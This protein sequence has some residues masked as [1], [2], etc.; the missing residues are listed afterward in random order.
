MRARRFPRNGDFLFCKLIDS[1]L[2]E[3]D[4]SGLAVP[5]YTMATTPMQAMITENNLRRSHS[6]PYSLTVKTYAQK[7]LEFQSAV[8]SLPI[9]L[10]QG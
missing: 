3:S 9:L 4:L 8:T 2:S 6:N 10:R 7:A 5:P 1:D